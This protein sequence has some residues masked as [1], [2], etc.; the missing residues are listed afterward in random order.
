VAVFVDVP[1]H[2]ADPTD[3]TGGRLVAAVS[4][5]R[6]QLLESQEH[7]QEL[8]IAIRQRLGRLVGQVEP[9]QQSA[10]LTDGSRHRREIANNLAAER[11]P[12]PLEAERVTRPLDACVGIERREKR[13]VVHKDRQKYG[14][15]RLAIRPRPSIIRGSTGNYRSRHQSGQHPGSVC[16][17]RFRASD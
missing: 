16:V 7:G 5:I 9:E 6:G 8:L 14:M 1:P 15:L 2:G 17:R 13:S 4:G 3:V 11:R 12:D 10:E